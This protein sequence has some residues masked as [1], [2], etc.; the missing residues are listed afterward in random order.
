MAKKLSGLGRGLDAL[1]PINFATD[2]V[3][4]GSKSGVEEIDIAVISPKLGQPRTIFNE[5]K[6][7]QLSY[8][9]KEHGILQPLVLVEAGNGEYVIIAGER[10]YRAAKIAGLKKVPAVIRTATELQQLELALVENIQREDLGSLEQSMS[11]KRLHEEFG[12]SYEQIARRLGKAQTT[13]VNLVRLLGL[14]SKHQKALMDGLINDGHA[15]AL[16]A[17]IKNPDAQKQLFKYI[18]NQHWSVRRA[19]L[20]VTSFKESDGSKEKTA[21]RLLT[22]TSETKTLSD[23]LKRDVRIH[24]TA[25]GGKIT[26]AFKDDTDLE[27]L[28]KEL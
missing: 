14:S 16:L 22:E 28:L 2:E 6:I 9:I 7:E 1:F 8:S 13:V 5:E 23:R 11:I 4:L 12:Q 3:L 10:R 17:L 18:I 15:R 27:K 24:R 26:I 20:F 25:K 21:V 19:E